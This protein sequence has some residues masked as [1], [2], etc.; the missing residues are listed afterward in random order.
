MKLK[1]IKE[2]YYP[3]VEL[4]EQSYYINEIEV[5]DELYT[6]YNAAMKEFWAVQDE[7]YKLIKEQKK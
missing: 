1:W 3:V 7:L 4:V 5:S 2:E 6:R